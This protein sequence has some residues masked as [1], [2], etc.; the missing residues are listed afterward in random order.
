MSKVKEIKYRPVPR[1]WNPMSAPSEWIYYP[2]TPSMS[3]DEAHKV[4]NYLVDK[5]YAVTYETEDGYFS[6]VNPY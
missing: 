3:T 2:V 1:K 5:G 4:V 6:N